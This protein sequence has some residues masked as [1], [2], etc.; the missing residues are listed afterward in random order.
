MSCRQCYAPGLPHRTRHI[1]H[2]IKEH[3]L[4]NAPSTHHDVYGYSPACV[5]CRQCYA[6]G[7]LPQLAP[8]YL[9]AVVASAGGAAAGGDSGERVSC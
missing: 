6:P 3:A 7:L 4:K 5:V 9:D 1:G 2:A 8:G